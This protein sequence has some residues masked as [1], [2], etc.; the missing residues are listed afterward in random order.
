MLTQAEI[1]RILRLVVAGNLLKVPDEKDV[2]SRR[3]KNQFGT[4]VTRYDP[5]P[6]KELDDFL[7][8]ICSSIDVDVMPGETDPA[9]SLL[10]QTPMPPSLFEKSCC[11]STF[12]SRTNP[13]EFKINDTLFIGTSGQNINDFFKYHD[14]TDRIQLAKYTLVSTHLAPTAPDTLYCQPFKSDDPF[15]INQLPNVYFCGNQEK[16]ESEMVN[17]NGSLVRIILVPEFS[18]TGELVLVN[19]N[20]LETRVVQFEC[21]F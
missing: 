14:S 21:S 13:Y 20:T 15:I 7:Y 2:A 19:S 9:S 6:L 11:C 5:Q 16:Y 18:K 4:M 8:S 17:I 1:S 3:E 12:Q 10:P